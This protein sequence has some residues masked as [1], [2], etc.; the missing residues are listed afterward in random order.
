MTRAPAPG[1]RTGSALRAGHE[2]GLGDKIGEGTLAEV[3]RATMT[4]PRREVAVKFLKASVAPGSQ[5]GQRF[6]REATLLAGFTHQNIPQVFAQGQTDDGRPYL[7]M[8]FVDGWTLQDVRLQAPDG[9]LPADVASIFALKIA[10]ALEHI[11]L[12]GVVHRDIKPGNVLVSRRGDV[13]L[14]DFGLAR[15][16]DDPTPETLGVVGT[17]AYMSPEQVLGDRLDDASDV[18]SFGIVFYELLTGRR[19]F[20]EEPARTV[21]QKIRL[22]RYTTARSIL[23]NL[24]GMLERILAR[25]LEKNPAHRYPSTGRLC[26]DLTE[27]L[28][29]AGVISHEARLV[30][31][32][33]EIALVD[34]DE[35]RTALG[36]MA[37][38]WTGTSQRFRLR[39]AFAGQLAVLGLGLVGAAGV[40][41]AA[42][43]HATPATVLG[44]RPSGAPGVG[45][46]RVLARPWA[47]ITV[48]GM[49]VDTTPLARAI[50]LSP[51]SHFVRLRNPSCIPE[52]RTIT[53][54]PD[55]T[56]WIDVDLAPASGGERAP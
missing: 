52:D 48:D 41:L 53:V 49:L 31:W 42:A 16:L 12:R 36:P 55:G 34:D 4:A 23:P 1:P 47:E 17:P 7:V 27:F 13:K 22:D 20:E 51:G 6:S 50:P 43:R 35:A 33:R 25:C 37:Q 40:E 10:R 18:F 19:P 54:V 28:A 45:Y 9:Q 5:L 30:G 56:L 44:P 21:M 2:L 11:H 46:L 14:A 38:G 15:V 32:M 29:R 8:E 26:D 3:Y 24:P 39:R